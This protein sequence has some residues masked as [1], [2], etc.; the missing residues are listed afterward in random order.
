MFFS[1][2]HCG[3]IFIL[4]Q[5]VSRHVRDKICKFYN[6]NNNPVETMT[7]T[8]TDAANTILCLIEN[9]NTNVRADVAIIED[10]LATTA[11]ITRIP[12]TI[13]STFTAVPASSSSTTFISTSNPPTLSESSTFD[14]FTTI[15]PL[16]MDVLSEVIIHTTTANQQLYDDNDDSQYS[17]TG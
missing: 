11:D 15:T 5:E 9:D 14:K 8:E 13:T 7:L 16:E 10:A 17:V 1:C 6:D 3:E 2:P 4:P 12:P